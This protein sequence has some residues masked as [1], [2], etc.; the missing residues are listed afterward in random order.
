MPNLLYNFLKW[1]FFAL[2]DAAGDTGELVNYTFREMVAF[3]SLLKRLAAK[4]YD[5]NITDATT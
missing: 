5:N 1:R 4:W 3:S 2:G